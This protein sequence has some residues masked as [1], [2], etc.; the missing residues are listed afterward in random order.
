M[1]GPF[2]RARFLALELKAGWL[3]GAAGMLTPTGAK[4]SHAPARRAA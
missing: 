3:D 1:P 4:L 2:E